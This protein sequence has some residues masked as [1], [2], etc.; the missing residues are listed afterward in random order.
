[1]SEEPINVFCRTGVDEW[2]RV[3]CH[4]AAGLEIER[5][6]LAFE[7]VWNEPSRNHWRQNDT[8]IRKTWDELLVPLPQFE[9]S[10][11]AYAMTYRVHQEEARQQN[12]FPFA[13]HGRAEGTWL[14][15]QHRRALDYEAEIALLLHRPEPERFG[16]LLANDLTDRGV[17]LRTFDRR[18]PAPGFSAA[19][20][21]PGALRVGPLLAVGGP[22]LW[23]QLEV[24]LRINGELRQ[25]VNAR[26]CLLTPQQFHQQIFARNAAT[27]WALV[28]TGTT[29]GTIFRSPRSAEKWALWIKHGFSKG[30]AREAWLRRF[31]FLKAGD[32]LEMTSQILGTSCATIVA[33]A[34]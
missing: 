23:P 34:E 16:F 3:I 28:L 13:K 8:S 32:Q 30:D 17:Q 5:R 26:E 2:N 29:G 10:S 33:K 12:I 21:F 6:T 7:Q 15:I 24:Q 20:S 25:Q 22:V 9:Q 14:P 11:W 31:Q 4:D 18:H 27:D 1:M 19:K